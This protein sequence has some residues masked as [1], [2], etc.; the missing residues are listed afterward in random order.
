MKEIWIFFTSSAPNTALSSVCIR[1]KFSS[2]P[3]LLIDEENKMFFGVRLR[4]SFSLLKKRKL[5]IFHTRMNDYF[6]QKALFISS[7]KSGNEM[8]NGEWNVSK[9]RTWLMTFLSANRW[10][11]IMVFSRSVVFGQFLWSE[12]RSSWLW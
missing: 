9:W 2:T 7:W 4:N 11:S 8:M 10:W 1:L 5:W 12:N 3:P 6:F